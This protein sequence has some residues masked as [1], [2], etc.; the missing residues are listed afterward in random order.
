MKAIVKDNSNNILFRIKEDAKSCLSILMGKTEEFSR[1]SLDDYETSDY[2]TVQALKESEKKINKAATEYES[3][4]GI[5][6]QQKK[7]NITK[8]TPK[9]VAEPNTNVINPII[10]R[11]TN[12]D[13]NI[14]LI[15]GFDNER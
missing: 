11:T 5:P 3:S 6:S 10:N 4:I 13:R 15:K 1:D 8:T 9:R 7:K 2:E 12:T 14:S